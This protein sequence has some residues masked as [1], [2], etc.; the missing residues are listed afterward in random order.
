MRSG[1]HTHPLPV[2]RD[3]AVSGAVDNV[4]YILGGNDVGNNHPA[5]LIGTP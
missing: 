5:V 2:N 1:T 3:D 4:F